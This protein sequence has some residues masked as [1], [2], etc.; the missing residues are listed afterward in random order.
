MKLALGTAQFG[1]KYGVANTGNQIDQET[2]FS[3]LRR[4]QELGWETLDTASAYGASELVLGAFG[5]QRWRVVSKLN[6]VP[7]QCRDVKGWVKKQAENSLHRLELKKMYGFL[8]H[9]PSQLTEV[10][11]EKLYE[12]LIALKDECLVEKVGISIY[13]PLE[14][15]VLSPEYRFDLIQAPLNIFDRRILESGW[16]ERLKKSG[17]ELHVRSAFLQG[18]LLMSPKDRPLKFDRWS[19]IWKEWDQWLYASGLS[20]LQACLRYVRDASF[21]DRIIIGVN[22]VAHLNQIALAIEGESSGLPEFPPI[23]DERLI[24]PIFWDQL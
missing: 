23:N 14:L 13:S 8:L 22:S 1:Q 12:A 21:V 4:S 7:N 10:G 5:V 3:I 18:L 9:K 19:T 24:N 17:A 15:E 16:A 2:A 6:A 11:G 20:P